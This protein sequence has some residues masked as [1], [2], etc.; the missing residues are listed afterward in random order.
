[1]QVLDWEL[2]A[3][4]HALLENLNANR[5]TAASRAQGGVRWATD[6]DGAPIIVIDESANGIFPLGV[7]K[8]P[9]W[10]TDY[11][12]ARDPFLKVTNRGS[13]KSS[14]ELMGFE[15]GESDDN[16]TVKH[17]SDCLFNI[18]F[19]GNDKISIRQNGEIKMTRYCGSAALGYLRRQQLGWQVYLGK[20]QANDFWKDVEPYVK[21]ITGK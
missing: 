18:S 2:G 8:I 11:Q 21:V 17:D 3:F 1:M 12:K 14:L 4:A 20:L 13:V 6:A 5:Y 7:P 9:G 10:E 19:N 16:L 15:I